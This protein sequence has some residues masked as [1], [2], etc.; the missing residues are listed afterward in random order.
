MHYL[1][2]TS[3]KRD[4]LEATDPQPERT[5][6]MTS[7]KEVADWCHTFIR[8]MATYGWRKQESVPAIPKNIEIPID[9]LT[10]VFSDLKRQGIDPLTHLGS[11]RTPDKIVIK[12]EPIE[13][14]T[15]YEAAKF[16]TL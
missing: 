12:I 7:Q 3:L 15:A 4:Y 8:L 2:K 13:P 1:I 5:Y 14:V 10:Q 9:R 16:F 11:K 6:G